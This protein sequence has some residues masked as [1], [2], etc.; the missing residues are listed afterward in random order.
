MA[1]DGNASR[2]DEDAITATDYLISY[3]G[4]HETVGGR[5]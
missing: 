1:R 4:T 2:S 3:Q 5:G